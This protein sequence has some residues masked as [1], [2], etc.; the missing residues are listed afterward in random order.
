MTFVKLKTEIFSGSKENVSAQVRNSVQ[1]VPVYPTWTAP[2]VRRCRPGSID[3]DTYRLGVDYDATSVLQDS[4]PPPRLLTAFTVIKWSCMVQ[5]RLLLDAKICHS[6]MVCRSMQ[7]SPFTSA[8]PQ[9]WINDK[10]VGKY[11]WTALAPPVSSE[12]VKAS[13]KEL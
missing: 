1:W 7:L 10:L 4:I 2:S 11:E 6:N 12:C 5:G 9:A 8:E 13:K 3:F